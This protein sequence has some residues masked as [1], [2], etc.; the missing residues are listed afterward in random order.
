M[1]IHTPLKTTIVRRETAKDRD[2]VEALGAAAFGPGRFTRVAFRLREGV[3]LD[4]SLSF[5]AT[6]KHH[7]V[8]SVRLTRILI[9]GKVA[10]LLGPL[11]IDPELRSFGIGRELM[12]RSLHE[13]RGDGHAYV[14]LVGDLAYY[15][16]F[17]FVPI[18]PGRITLP[19]PAA[20]DRILGY[21]LIPG[22][23]DRFCGAATRFF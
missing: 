19:G 2:A 18:P 8:G 5:V 11:V 17:G 7:V 15:G 22:A 12:N 20:P 16:R 3:V 6:D 9:G 4:P 1:N 14:I 13:A 21:A 10:L 23:A